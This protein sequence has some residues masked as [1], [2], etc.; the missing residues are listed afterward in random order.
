MKSF[1]IIPSAAGVIAL[2]AAFWFAPE[3]RE[4]EFREVEETRVVVLS[5]IHSADTSAHEPDGNQ[6]PDVYFVEVS[7][8]AESKEVAV[9]AYTGKV[10][11]KRDI[12][13]KQS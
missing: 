8:G 7:H 4:N 5:S 11:G 10:L 6:T 12:T 13:T 9:N 2:T 3:Q 1:R